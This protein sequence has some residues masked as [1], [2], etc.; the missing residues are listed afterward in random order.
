MP[1][2]A[3]LPDYL[4]GFFEFPP[5]RMKATEVVQ[6]KSQLLTVARLARQVECE[7][8]MLQCLV[9]AFRE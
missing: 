4:K 2:F 5:A 1:Q 7:I 8:A 6:D 3:R 9:E